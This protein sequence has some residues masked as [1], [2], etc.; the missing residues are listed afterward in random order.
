MYWTRKTTTKPTI[1]VLEPRK[2]APKKKFIINKVVQDA[3]LQDIEKAI[4]LEITKKIMMK[5][6]G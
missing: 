4:E 1:I 6:L 5:G 2:R 3:D